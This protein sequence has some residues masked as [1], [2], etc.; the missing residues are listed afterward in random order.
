[1]G[2]NVK[3]KKIFVIPYYNVKSLNSYFSVSLGIFN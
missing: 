2:V 3:F 1:M